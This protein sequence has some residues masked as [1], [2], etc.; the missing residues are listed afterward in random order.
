MTAL[1]LT[2][3]R[4]VARLPVMSAHL[5]CPPLTPAGA[6]SALHKNCRRQNLPLDGWSLIR[7]GENAMFKQPAA[8]LVARVARCQHRQTKVLKEILVAQWLEHSDFPAVRLASGL[9]QEPNLRPHPIT[10][11]T[12]GQA[13]ERGVGGLKKLGSLLKRLHSQ[14]PPQNLELP[15][16][17]PLADV[18]D[19]LS[20]T[21]HIF[22]Q[23]HLFLTQHYT[24]LQKSFSEILQPSTHTVIHG[25]A[26]LG[27]LI[28]TA[29]GGILCDFEQ[30]CLG[31]PL[32]DAIPAII[33]ARRFGASPKE[34]TDFVGEL[35][36]PA[37]PD[38]VLELLV[39]LRELTMVTWLGQLVEGN[40][41]AATEYQ[42]RV[43]TLRA[44]SR[45]GG[46]NAF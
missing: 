28:L 12:F 29:H 24:E 3:L 20:R 21:P 16:F 45:A 30:V 15:Q 44:G 36:L 40:K 23:E 13:L 39:Q 35:E 14:T 10:Y 25:D 1:S 9:A 2:N 5:N 34:T 26:H 37:S 38:H 27:N 32:W 33:S 41:A 11:W 4:L 17:T 18:A 19:R 31:P 42:H 46:W 6:F 8:K 43:H 7:L 22:T